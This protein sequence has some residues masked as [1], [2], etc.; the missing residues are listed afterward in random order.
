MAKCKLCGVEDEQMARSHIIPRSLYAGTIRSEAGPARIIS[1]EDSACP[2]RSPNGVYDESILCLT[3]ESSLSDLDDYANE[4]FMET[5]P[6]EVLMR[7]TE[8][9]A[10]KY[11]SVDI[12]KL[13]LFFLSL[14]WRMNAT[15]HEMFAGVKLGPY[16]TPVTE[17]LLSRD[18]S[19]GPQVDIVISKFQDDLAVGFLG[20]LPMRIEG[21][22]GYRVCFAYHS[23]WLKVDKREFPGSF[24]HIAL[25]SGNP[26]HILSSE[27][28][29]NPEKRAMVETVQS[30]N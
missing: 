10:E 28:D 23:C 14:L 13:Q 24:A 11:E 25:S 2:R 21:V 6:S 1:N 20:P 8:S 29:G 27:F 4:F 7:G 17:A 15:N 19:L 3:C 12:E 22:N 9:L 26:L 5:E 18:L 30:Q 16:E